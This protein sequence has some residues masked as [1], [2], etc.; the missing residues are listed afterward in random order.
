MPGKVV[1]EILHGRILNIGLGTVLQ[2]QLGRKGQEFK[3]AG[4]LVGIIPDE[5]L[6]VRAPAIPGILSRLCEG[7]PIVVRYIYAGNVYGFTSIIH[8]CIQKPALIV[9]IAY[10]TSVE[11]MNL[12]Q[13]GRLECF[14]P[15]TVEVNGRDHKAVILDISL[16]GCKLFIENEP[17]ESPPP[18]DIGQTIGIRFLLMGMAEE[19]VINGTIRNM[20]KDDKHTASGIQFDQENSAVLNNLKLYMDRYAAVCSTSK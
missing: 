8:S 18:I 15:A 12:R 5:H 2:F 14:F 13:A 19:Q 16:S 4:V 3:A 10:P 11:S 7:N 9:F 20:K 6:M 17:D 1:E